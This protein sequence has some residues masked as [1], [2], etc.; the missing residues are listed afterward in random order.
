MAIFQAIKV[1]FTY[2]EQRR[3]FSGR[4]GILATIG[5]RRRYKNG[6]RAYGM[7]GTR[8]AARRRRQIAKGMLKAE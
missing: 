6:K 7:N 8:P 5:P 1:I 4:R 3:R 2:D